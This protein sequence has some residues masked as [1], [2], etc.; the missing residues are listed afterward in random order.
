MAY[1]DVAPEGRPN[2]RTVVL[3]HGMNFGGFYFA[4]PIEML[5]KEGFRVIVTGSD[6][7]RPVVEADHSVQLERSARA[8]RARLLQSLGISKA[9]IVGHSGGGMLAARFAASYPGHDRARR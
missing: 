9:V 7:I 5:R 6:R 3:L 2:G 4:G 8:I 1:M